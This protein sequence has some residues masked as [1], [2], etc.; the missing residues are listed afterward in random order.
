[1]ASYYKDG[2]KVK[3][4]D[5][6]GREGYLVFNHT[7]SMC[8]QGVHGGTEVRVQ[9][10]GLAGERSFLWGTDCGCQAKLFEREQRLVAQ[11]AECTCSQCGGPRT[12]FDYGEGRV[13][14]GKGVCAN[15]F[16]KGIDRVVTMIIGGGTGRDLIA[17]AG[18]DEATQEWLAQ[19]GGQA[20][21]LMVE[22]GFARAIVPQVFTPEAMGNGGGN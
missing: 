16:G 22:A 3:P 18:A 12:G 6:R 7:C 20:T 14:P 2:K 11:G 9:V 1:M 8:G 5:K 13:R 4:G 10:H 21:E 17:F 15:C 19:C